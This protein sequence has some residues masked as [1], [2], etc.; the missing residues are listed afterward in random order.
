MKPFIAIVALL[1]SVSAHAQYV[2]YYQVAGE[3]QQQRIQQ[4]QA[5]MQYQYQQQQLEMQ[6]E[7]WQEMRER[8]QQ[9]YYQPRGY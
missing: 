1:A 3:L 4:Q 2:P 8:Q 5:Q 9:S 6:R 7:Q